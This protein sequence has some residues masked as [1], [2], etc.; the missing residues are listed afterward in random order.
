MPAP[1][2]GGDLSR[3]TA[4]SQH[5]ALRYR[6]LDELL[7]GTREFVLDG[8]AV[9]EPVLVAAPT[10]TLELL[11]AELPVP[12]QQVSMVDMRQAGRNPGAIIPQ[13]LLRFATEH[14]GRRVR[15]LAEPVWPGRT[16]EEYPACVQHEALIN[17]VFAGRD[18]YIRCVY[19]AAGLAPDWLADVARTHPWIGTGDQI[20]PSRHY[21]DPAATAA[22]FN[23]PLPEP[24]A[25]AVRLVV[26][27]GTLSQLRQVAI[28]QAAAA[29]LPT[30]RVGDLTIALNELVTNSIQYG[31]G[32]AHVAIWVAG[33]WVIGQVSDAGHIADPLAGRIPPAPG[34]RGGGRGLVVV[35]ALCD[36]VRVH[37][38]PGR[39][40]VRVQLRR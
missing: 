26:R 25:G 31:G 20:G 24:P 12:D 28:T 18:A 23:P 17:T 3:L 19:D 8:L 40:T 29:G 11:R 27:T 6:D 1:R 34:Q 13:V 16:D 5:A 10:R 39:T 22:E 32:A 15:I 2:S 7:A 35:N 9:G 14:S 37:T 4:P 36:L 30:G 33:D 38:R 21:Q